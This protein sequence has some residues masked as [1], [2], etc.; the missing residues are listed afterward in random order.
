M[1]V[2]QF[3]GVTAASGKEIRGVRDA[4]NPKALRASLRREG[5]VLTNATEARA[6]SEKKARDIQL[7][8][9]LSRPNTG[10]VALV[11]RQLATLIKAGIPLA[12]SIGALAEQVEKDQFKHVLAAVREQVNEGTAFADALAEHPQVFPSL[13]INMV[14]A[15]EASGTLETVLDR[16]ATFM[17]TQAKLKGK[18]MAAM[19]YPI[20]M[21]F[22]G[23]ILIS[24]LMIGVVPKVTAIFASLER[25]LPWYTSLLIIVSGAFSSPISHGILVGA[26]IGGP[27]YMLLS[28][29]PPPENATEARAKK[30]KKKGGTGQTTML[31]IACLIGLAELLM[32]EQMLRFIVSVVPGLVIGAA[33]GATLLWMKTPRG[34]VAFDGMLLQLPIFGKLFQMIAVARFANTL[35]TLLA[36]GVQLLRAMDIVRA[37]IGNAAL[38]K[39]VEDA[40]GSIREG[41]SIAEPLRRSK[42]FPP[43]VT[44]MIAVGEKSGQL[45]QMLEAVT[46]SYES[47]IETRIT[48]L[49]SLLEPLM[50]VIMGGAVG[51]IAFA[52]LMPLIQMND[53]NQ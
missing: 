44:H 1:A 9:F 29:T 27:G 33:V 21:L 51:F 39:V 26:F 40:T 18:V 53:F 7:F 34:K 10:D 22:I 11:T 16:L 30:P 23:G 37:V 48:A 41:E 15:G 52:I 50:I 46:S 24:V 25:A 32:R 8:A 45:E 31:G 20:L 43:I 14:A 38:E 2:F 5:I 17:D 3:R 28:D 35:S 6:A 4:D 36:S 49:T 19:A 13:Y 12:D 42:R 47:A